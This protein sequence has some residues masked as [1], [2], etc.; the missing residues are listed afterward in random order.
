M[1][2]M[3]TIWFRKRIEVNT[4]PLRRCYD[5]HHFKSK[6]IW[7][8]WCDIYD[9]PSRIDAEDSAKTFKTINPSN[10]YKVLPKGEMP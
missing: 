10:E 7:T 5:G 6:M 3:F 1:S 2:G 4:D 8:D 9:L